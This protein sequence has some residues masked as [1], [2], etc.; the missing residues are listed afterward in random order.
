LNGHFSLSI[1]DISKWS[2]RFVN[3]QITLAEPSVKTTNKSSFQNIKSCAL[4]KF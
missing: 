2:K 3:L 4:V 1:L